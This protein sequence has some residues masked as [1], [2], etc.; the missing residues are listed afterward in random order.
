MNYVKLQF[1]KKPNHAHVKLDIVGASLVPEIH[2]IRARLPQSFADDNYFSFQ[3][4]FE[5]YFVCRP[6]YR[7]NEKP[8]SQCY[9]CFFISGDGLSPAPEPP[10]NG[11]PFSTYD[12]DNDAEPSLNCADELKGGWWF[13]RCTVTQNSHYADGAGPHSNLNGEYSQKTNIYEYSRGI[14]WAYIDKKITH[15]EMKMRRVP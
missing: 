5:L 4:L 1:L 8:S 6:F 7:T 14:V 13:N 3:I 2:K 11:Q 15:S 9:I 12:R 10:S